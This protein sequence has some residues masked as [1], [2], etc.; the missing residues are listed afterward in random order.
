[1][2]RGWGEARCQWWVLRGGAEG[3]EVAAAAEALGTGEGDRPAAWIR[4]DEPVAPVLRHPAGRKGSS[5]TARQAARL[6]ATFPAVA[7]GSTESDRKRR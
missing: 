6:L 7:Q 1:M 5:Q 3:A 2:N 4:A